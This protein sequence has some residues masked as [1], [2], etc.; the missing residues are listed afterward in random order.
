MAWVIKIK[1]P[2]KWPTVRH[3]HENKN[4]S[5]R[6]RRKKLCQSIKYSSRF[7]WRMFLP[8]RSP[9]FDHFQGYLLTVA[10]TTSS[11]DEMGTHFSFGLQMIL[12]IYIWP[13]ERYSYSPSACLCISTS[14]LDCS[15]MRTNNKNKCPLRAAHQTERYTYIV[16]R[17]EMRAHLSV[18]WEFSLFSAHAL[19]FTVGRILVQAVLINFYVDTLNNLCARTTHVDFLLFIFIFYFP[20]I[21]GKSTRFCKIDN[22][23]EPLTYHEF[24]M[25]IV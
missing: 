1:I 23:Y 22:F 21:S 15:Y 14:I 24:V 16:V 25:S 4:N 2:S 9:H 3:V 8:R 20:L 10:W 7:A 12:A 11:A 19:A 18:H 6:K 5:N 13:A 17:L